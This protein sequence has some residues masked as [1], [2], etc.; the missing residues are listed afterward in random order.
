MLISNCL[1]SL[2]LI[3]KWLLSAYMSEKL[4]NVFKEIDL[5]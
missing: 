3:E 4:K 1:Y 5:M 2:K